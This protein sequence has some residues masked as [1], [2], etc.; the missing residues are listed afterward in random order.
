MSFLVVL[1]THLQPFPGMVGGQVAMDV[2]FA[3]SGFLITSLLMNEHARIGRVNLRKFYAR[4]AL[5]LFPALWVFLAVWLA[6]VLLLGP[7]N[8]MTAVPGATHPEP[9]R[10]LPAVEG[11]L[12]AVM[13]SSNWFM[14]YHLFSGYVALGHLWSLAVEDQFY[15]IW[16]PLVAVMLA[17]KRP[18]ALPVTLGLVAASIAASVTLWHGSASELRIYFGTDTRAASLLGGAAAAQLWSGGRLDRLFSGSLGAPV[19]GAATTLTIL[20]G[21]WMHDTRSAQA[22]LSGW[23]VASLSSP[24][25]VAGLVLRSKGVAST[26]LSHRLATFVG[27]RSYA[28]YLWHYIWVTWVHGIGWF[29]VPVVVALSFAAAELSWHLVEKRALSAKRRL[30]P[31]DAAQVGARRDAVLQHAGR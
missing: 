3:L 21:F 14:A 10:V 24:L 20:S 28:L 6:A 5:R 29:R 16:A 9:Q 1:A 31:L 27:Q 2:F 18:I 7:A 22:W 8:W 26:L 19:L 15:L 25:M 17:A 11:V 4:R 30:S 23:T 13:Y 12:A